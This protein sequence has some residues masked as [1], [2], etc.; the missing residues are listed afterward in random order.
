MTN[1]TAVSALVTLGLGLAWTPFALAEA[2]AKPAEIDT[3]YD[4][5]PKSWGRVTRLVVPTYPADLL[6]A[7]VEGVVDVEVLVGPSGRVKTIREITS[8]PKNAAMEE[9]TRAVLEYWG[10]VNPVSQQCIPVET[11]AHARVHFNVENGTPKI[12]LTHRSVTPATRTAE[13]TDTTKPKLISKN[14]AEVRSTIR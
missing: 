11:V 13:A 8:T 12:S 1:T 3:Q 7:G 10:F 6:T 9:A 5:D 4:S 14:L 2:P